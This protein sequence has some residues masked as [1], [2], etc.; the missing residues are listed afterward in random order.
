LKV[1]R[2]RVHDSNDET[3]REKYVARL[4]KLRCEE[5]YD[6]SDQDLG[7]DVPWLKTATQ[8][9]PIRNGERVL[10]I[11]CSARRSGD[12]MIRKK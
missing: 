5:K 3:A 10:C 12:P 6:A 7:S 9:G 1:Q 11:I 2:K 8:R 4:A